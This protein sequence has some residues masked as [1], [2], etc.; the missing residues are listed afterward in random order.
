MAEFVDTKYF[1]DGHAVPDPDDALSHGFWEAAREG[2]L[3]V[4]QCRDCDTLQ[5]PPELICHACHRFDLGWKDVAGRATIY[6]FTRT[7][8]A[9][10]ALLRERGPY[11]VVLLELDDHPEIRLLGNV[12]DAD[13]EGALSIGMRVQVVFERTQSHSD[14]D[15]IVQPRWRLVD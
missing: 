12:L 6:S 11:N 1:P 13:D 9:A 2:R 10:N 7:V 15:E 14:A 3:V 8:H 4:Q 5:H